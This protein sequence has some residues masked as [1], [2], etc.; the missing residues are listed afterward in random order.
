VDAVFGAVIKNLGSNNIRNECAMTIDSSSLQGDNSEF[1]SWVAKYKG[2]KNHL[3]SDT[4]CDSYGYNT[5]GEDF[6][7]IKSN[8]ESLR[9]FLWTIIISKQETEPWS[10]VPGYLSLDD[11]KDRIGYLISGIP[12]SNPKEI[13]YY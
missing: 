4:V 2:R 5:Y 9:S 8:L 10:I 11:N 7:Y 1:E 13:F 3:H 12:W 6:E